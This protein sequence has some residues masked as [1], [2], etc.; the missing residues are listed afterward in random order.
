[1]NER[2]PTPSEEA[3]YDAFVDRQDMTD[4][5]RSKFSQLEGKLAAKKTKSGKQKIKNPGGLAYAI[6]KA[7]YGAAAMAK[8]AAAGKAK[9]N[10]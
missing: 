10:K 6:G 9:A 1:M 5:E 4:E 8:K 2:P 7:K 3:E